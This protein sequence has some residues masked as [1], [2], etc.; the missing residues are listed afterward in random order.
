M[1]A[2]DFFAKN[3]S[4]GGLADWSAS[5]FRID[6]EVSSTKDSYKIVPLPVWA[7]KEGQDPTGLIGSNFLSINAYSKNPNAALKVI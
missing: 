2:S 7:G 3:P 6:T 4:T 5:K 1:G